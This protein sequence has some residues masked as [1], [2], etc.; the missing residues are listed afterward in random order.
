LPNVIRPVRKKLQLL[1]EEHLEHSR[2]NIEIPGYF[3]S[4]SFDWR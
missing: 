2:K 4:S 1:C 3:G